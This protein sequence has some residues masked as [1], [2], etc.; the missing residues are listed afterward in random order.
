IRGDRRQSQRLWRVGHDAYDRDL[1]F[2]GLAQVRRQGNG[3]ARRD[4]ET[5]RAVAQRFVEDWDVSFAEPRGNPEVDMHGRSEGRCRFP[6][7][8]AKRIPEERNT[9]RQ[10]NADAHLPARLEVAGCEVRTV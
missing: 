9:L 2:L 3:I 6:D 7:A 4:D 1:P 10:L 8:L 5:V